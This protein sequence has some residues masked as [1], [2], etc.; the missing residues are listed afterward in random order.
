MT[1]M[2]AVR[3]ARHGGSNVLEY[4]D[5]PMPEMG[6]GD[7]LVRVEL[8]SVS[9]WDVKYRNGHL[10]ALPGRAAFPLPMQPG[11][12]AVGVVE[13][14]G[15]A[16]TMFA[17]GDRVIGLVHPAN[18]ASELTIR[19]LGNLST[20]ILYPGHTMFG[21]AAQFVV[22]PEHY[23]LPIPEGVTMKAA[24]AALWSYATS[25]RILVERAGVAAGDTLLV[26]GASGGM[27]TA[28]LDL[29]RLMG[30]RCIAATRDAAKTEFLLG[31]GAAD[32]IVLGDDDVSQVRALG[33]PLGVDAMVD[34]SGQASMLRMGLQTLRPGGTMIVVAGEHGSDPIPVTAGDFVRLELN[35]KGARAST[36]D[37]Q[38]TILR[39][40]AQGALRPAVHAVMPLSETAAAQDLLSASAVQ[41][42]LLLDPWAD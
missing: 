13:A 34:F 24:A 21:G 36:I 18:P 41:G 3:H 9:G 5:Y 10:T 30:V 26:I 6:P 28:T 8:T 29:A 15:E 22:R 35:V 32:V 38:R 4:G 12:D 16:V 2:K 33:G 42:R 25:R 27:G 20:D 7:L 14:I 40:L 39:L 37:D 17:P 11:R 1:M 31:R 19:G 23:W